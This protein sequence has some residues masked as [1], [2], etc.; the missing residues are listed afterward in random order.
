M[1]NV[2]TLLSRV[3]L[4]SDECTMYILLNIKNVFIFAANKILYM[5]LIRILQHWRDI[6]IIIFKS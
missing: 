2:S 3:A 6:S 5:I 4:I 1:H